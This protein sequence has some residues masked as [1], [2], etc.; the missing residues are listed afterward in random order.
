MP[1]YEYECGD[2]GGKFEL[3]QKITEEPREK[4]PSCG[5]KLRRLIS[6]GAGLIFKGKGF[7]ATDYRSESYRRQEKKEREDVGSAAADRP[8]TG[9]AESEKKEPR[10]S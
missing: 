3:F 8:D 10:T 9:K 6:P 7:Y 1:T 5:G 2:C 4:C